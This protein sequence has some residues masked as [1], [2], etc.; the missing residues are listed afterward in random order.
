MLW[1]RKN[2]TWRI[3]RKGCK[4]EGFRIR[5][6]QGVNL[7]MLHNLVR[8]RGAVSNYLDPETPSAYKRWLEMEIDETDKSFIDNLEED[9]IESAI[10]PGDEDPSV[11]K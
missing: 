4:E 3:I 10:D 7:I 9:E 1:F 11:D 6:L 8:N 5:L 2:K